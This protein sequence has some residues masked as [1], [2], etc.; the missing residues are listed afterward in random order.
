VQ[1]TFPDSFDGGPTFYAQHV[2]CALYT[3]SKLG[4]EQVLFTT[5][6]CN[7]K[8][9]ATYQVASKSHRP[10]AAQV[11]NS[12]FDTL[13]RAFL[14]ARRK[15]AQLMLRGACLPKSLQPPNGKSIRYL[16]AIEYQGRGLPHVHR[17]D[18]YGG[19]RC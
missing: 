9:R 13:V 4:C 16:E 8:S 7:S 5:M 10:S 18:F 17:L 11:D 15:L 19:K 1:S 3:A 2:G 14:C 12:H 6:T